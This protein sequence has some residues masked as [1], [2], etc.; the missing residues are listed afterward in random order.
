MDNTYTEEE[1]ER[2]TLHNRREIAYQLRGM[3]KRG[4]RVSVLFQEGRQSFLT[5]LIDVSEADGLIYFDIGGSPE[6]NQ[7]YLK[8]AHSTFTTHIDGIRLQFSVGP[9][10]ETRFGG[11]RV[12]AVP[13][14]KS[15]LRLQRREVFRLA[16]PSAKPHSNGWHKPPRGRQSPPSNQMCA[17]HSLC[18]WPPCVQPAAANAA[19]RLPTWAKCVPRASPVFRCRTG[20]AS[21]SG[22]THGRWPNLA[23]PSA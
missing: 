16:L 15:L 19:P 14:P 2:C 4:D 9:G 17:R 8:A 20:F 7:A 6:T 18:P 13:L 5:V 10:K 11:E 1:I 3:V 12:F 22:P 21:P 23:C